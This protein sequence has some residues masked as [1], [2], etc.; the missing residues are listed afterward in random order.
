[1][2]QIRLS[3]SLLGVVACGFMM[4]ATAGAQQT[5]VT[6]SD[7]VDTQSRYRQI[8]EKIEPGLAGRPECL[9]LYVEHFRREMINDSR[10]FPF[11]VDAR[12]TE[13][14]HIV[15]T[16]FVGYE[17]NRTA[18]MNFM[19]CLGFEQLDD[20][21]EVLPSKTLAN[22][23]FGFVK[24]SHVFSFDRPT[25]RQSVLTDCL[26]GTPVYLLKEVAGGFFLCQGVEGYVGY[27]EAKAIHRVDRREFARYQSGT[28]LRVRRDF[29]TANGLFV[30]TGARLK[31]VRRRGED[32]VAE[33][34]TGDEVILPGDHCELHDGEPGPRINRVIENALRMVGTKYVWGG[35]TSKGIDCSGLMQTAFA[36][37]GVHLPRD[38]NQQIYPGMLT[39]TR[40][41]REG[42][43]RGDTLY[44]LNEHGKISHTAI[45]LGDG[46]CLEAV[47]PVVRQASF[48]RQDENYDQR[49]D[50][51]FCFAKR[52]LD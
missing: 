32:V 26:L 49:L 23:P 28:Q 44:F 30:P 31:Y 36:A 35:N 17:E 19:H 6:E 13:A 45:Y 46:Q 43:R 16:G 3:A 11:H 10:L 22:Q 7:S 15:L 4:A 14:G 39:A 51:A 25:G 34:P 9:P 20:R 1:M 29:Q 37:E 8:V 47:R 40:W 38:S 50:E 5:P 24:I 12:S 33:L 27:L 18:L 41:Y 52:L 2:C 48:R 21:I 42:L